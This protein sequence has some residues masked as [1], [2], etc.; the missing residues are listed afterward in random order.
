MPHKRDDIVILADMLA[1]AQEVVEFV[2]GKSW[3]EYESDTQLRRAVERSVELIGEAARRISREFENSHPD[4]PWNKII[5]QRHRLAHEYD[6]LDDGIIWSVA[7]KYVPEL[8]TQ[9]TP[10][11]DQHTKKSD[12]TH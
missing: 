10:I 6:V 1:F 9:I 2:D 7:I 5:V 11:I 8:I 12:S 4:I 3:D